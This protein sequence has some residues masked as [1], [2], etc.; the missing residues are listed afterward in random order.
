[1]N[2][3]RLQAAFA[4]FFFKPI[5]PLPLCT[6]RVLYGLCVFATLTL[7][8]SDWLSWFGVHSWISMATMRQIEPEMRLNLF[9][10]IPQDDH[11]IRGLFWLLL[12]ASISLTVGLW[13]R[14]SS[15][16]VFLGL[17]SLNQRMP[18]ITHGGDTFL[19]L[20]GFFLMFAPAGK[21]LSIDSLIRAH[22][23]DAPVRPSAPWAQRMIQYQLA[24][25][26]LM[27]FWWKAKGHT[28]WDGTAL[29]YV[30]HLREI[31]RFPIPLWI[32]QPLVLRL[33]GWFTLGFELCFPL[34]IWF[35][36]FQY[37]LLFLGVLFH[38]SLEYALNLPMFE[39]D[40]LA[41]YVLFIGPEDL[42]RFAIRLSRVWPLLLSQ[43]SSD[44][45][46]TE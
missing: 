12:I 10:V 16:I 45:V 7:L 19:R 21:M 42:R 34:A 46:S 6:F 30:V 33:G 15:I 22:R 26:Y 9:T 14:V 40:M 2:I 17:T 20:A 13:T 5:S 29:Y 31:H 18:F 32:Q 11:W 8:Y 1:M 23:N 27:S 38:L 36:Q 43:T 41:A 3:R 24:I 37:P 28:W 25:I 35:R 4:E 44:A 39:W